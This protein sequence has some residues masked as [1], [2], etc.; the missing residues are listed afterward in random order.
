MNGLSFRNIDLTWVLLMAITINN[1][2][3]A[4]TADTTLLISIVIATATAFKGYMVVEHFMGLRNANRFI[5]NMMRAYFFVIPLLIV[6]VQAF[7]EQIAR[8]TQ[9]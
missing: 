2:I 5:R 4:E 9:L 7:P 3:I 1:A 8:M 6:L